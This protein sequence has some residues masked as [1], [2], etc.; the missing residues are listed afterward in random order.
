MI[1]VSQ[2]ADGEKVYCQCCSQCFTVGEKLGML[3]IP[4]GGVPFRF[5]LCDRCDRRANHSQS[6]WRKVAIC[7]LEN[8][9]DENALVMIVA[10]LLGP[11]R[12]KTR[13]AHR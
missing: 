10:A 9:P 13:R 5:A 7:V 1:A 12:T 8:Q 11:K 2:P 3:E 4:F 6:Q